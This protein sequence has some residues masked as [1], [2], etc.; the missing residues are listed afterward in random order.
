MESSG[1]PSRR[2]PQF[3]SHS[4]AK[5]SYGR[6]RMTL[7]PTPCTRIVAFFDIDGTLLPA[8]SLERRM[9]AALRNAGAIPLLNYIRWFI[10]AAQVTPTGMAAIANANK[11]HLR[12][13]PMD[14]LRESISNTH[15]T[16]P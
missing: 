1:S 6:Y 2:M 16:L 8:P 14:L 15:T 13:V 4:P 5:T 9:F 11:K 7:F 10:R 3:K 12:A